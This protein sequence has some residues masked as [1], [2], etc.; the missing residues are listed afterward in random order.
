M[1]L[2]RWSVPRLLVA[3]ALCVPFAACQ[4]DPSTPQTPSKDTVSKE[5]TSPPNANKNGDT[6]K[7]T[8]SPEKSKPE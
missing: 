4:K 7:N 6:P 2:R 3:L 1:T 8:A 5:K